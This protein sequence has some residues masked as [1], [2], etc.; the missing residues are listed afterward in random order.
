MNAKE[1]RERANSLTNTKAEK[2]YNEIQRLIEDA[3]KRSTFETY[4]YESLLPAVHTKLV[5]EGF[6]ISDYFDQRDGTTVTI[7]W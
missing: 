5:N 6:D 2:Q 1:A 3:V 4:Y 7:S